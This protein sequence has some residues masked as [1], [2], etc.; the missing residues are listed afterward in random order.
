[1]SDNFLH[2]YRILEHEFKNQVQKDSAELK[3]IYLPNPI[4]PEEPVDYVFVGMEPSLGSWTEGKSDDDRLKI[5]QDKID[6]GFRNFECSIEDF[7]I[8]YCIR[9]YLCQDPEKYYITDLSKGAMSTSLAKK[10]RNK[11]Y[12]SWYPLL[13]KEITLVSKPEAKVIA[14]GYGLH[15]FLLKHQFEEKAGRKIYRI[16]HYSKQAV[17]CHNKYI[18]D[19]AQYEGFYPLISINDILKVAEDMLSKRE[20][21]DNI[22]KEIYNKLPK[23]LA[24]AKKKLIFCYKSE[25]EKIKSGCS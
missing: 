19:N 3:S 22:K 9:N 8:H 7:S 20:T 18:A 16:P 24:E 4:I 17:G 1:M 5:A 2:S 14:I 12:E 13:I 25:F 10:K 21:D 11:R 6:R 23:T 15:G